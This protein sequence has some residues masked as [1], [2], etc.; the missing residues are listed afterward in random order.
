MKQQEAE[1]I[2]NTW[3]YDG[4]YSFYDQTNDLEDYEIL[5]DPKKRINPHF[6]CFFENEL[7]GFYFI[8]LKE[9]KTIVLD[10]GLKPEFTG[11]G[12]G[13]N[14]IKSILDHIFLNHKIEEIILNVAEFNKRAIKVYERVGF[15]KIEN[16]LQKV[17][18]G[19][20]NFI[21]MK[22]IINIKIEF[23]V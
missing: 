12:F 14:F 5:T 11:R 16:Y 20:Y 2:A 9:N 6:S 13:E 17:N 7:I 22:K 10:L 21:R 23:I 8:E 4:I 15:V 3:K 18:G 19:E 1:D